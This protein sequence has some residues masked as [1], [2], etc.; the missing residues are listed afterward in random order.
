[1]LMLDDAIS[2]TT[3]CQCG[4]KCLDRG[5]KHPACSVAASNGA[6]VLFVNDDTDANCRYRGLRGEENICACPTHY[7]IH[8]KHP[9]INRTLRLSREDG[10][11]QRLHPRDD[12]ALPQTVAQAVQILVAELS[13]RDKLSIAHM[14]VEEIGESAHRLIN[15]VQDT[16]ALKS[17]N[18]E[19]LWSCSK[20]AD[21]EIEHPEDASAIILARLVVELV[22]I[23][24]LSAV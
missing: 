18:K 4:F 23:H 20:D 12:K 22:K 1:M 14:G 24:K 21:R 10:S 17:G 3:C 2:K 19:L 9:Y 5:F 15:Y 7:A 6:N 13:L 16:L 11:T 8:N